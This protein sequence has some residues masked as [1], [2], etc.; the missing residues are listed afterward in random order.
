MTRARRSRISFLLKPI[1]TCVKCNKSYQI[2]LIPNGQDYWMGFRVLILNTIEN[3]TWGSSVLSLSHIPCLIPSLIL[4]HITD[5]KGMRE[6][7]RGKERHLW[8]FRIGKL[9]SLLKSV[10][11]VGWKRYFIAPTG[12]TLIT[13]VT[14]F[15]WQQP[16][17]Q[18]IV[19][20]QKT[21]HASSFTK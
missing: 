2:L 13:G 14:Q 10:I 7:M 11:H 21:Y 18:S 1:S 16:A 6:R 17:D 4:R 3:R 8:Y 5:H 19:N 15:T 9:N 20:K 12:P